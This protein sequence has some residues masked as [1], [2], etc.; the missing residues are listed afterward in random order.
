MSKQRGSSLADVR[1]QGCDVGL[2]EAD[3]VAIWPEL[4]ASSALHLVKPPVD[5]AAA[6]KEAIEACRP[7]DGFKK[8]AWNPESR[9]ELLRQFDGLTNAGATYEGAL[10]ELHKAW[11][12]SKSSDKP[13]GTL[14]KKLTA[15]RK[16]R[17]EQQPRRHRTG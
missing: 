11:G 6:L 4:A 15:A 3:A 10:I 16:E 13:G 14:G 9:A 1:V 7:P 12:Y 5:A 8:G 17:D 2:T